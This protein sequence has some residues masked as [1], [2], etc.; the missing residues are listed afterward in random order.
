VNKLYFAVRH[1][2]SLDFLGCLHLE[3][4]VNPTPYPRFAVS[5]QDVNTV[6]G[7]WD[8]MESDFRHLFYE[9]HLQGMFPRRRR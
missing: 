1:Y 7:E 9:D 2:G 5:H 6:L 4:Y 3:D 8:W